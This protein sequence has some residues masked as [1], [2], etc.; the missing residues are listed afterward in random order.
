[1]SYLKRQ[2]GVTLVELVLVLAITA[3]AITTAIAVRSSMRKDISFSTSI[4][5]IKNQIV[6]AKN[7]S[8]QSVKNNSA[9][10]GNTNSYDFG[11]AVEFFPA[12]DPEV[13]AP[14]EADKYM[15]VS[16]LISEQD[17][18]PGEGI[19]QKMAQC[20]QR[21]ELYKDG[22]EYKGTEKRAIIF[23]RKP[24]RLFVTPLNHN[25]T[26]GEVCNTLALGTENTPN[27]GGYDS[28]NDT[29]P[30]ATDLCPYEPGPAPSGCPGGT[31]P[32]VTEACDANGYQCGLY[33]RFYDRLASNV[34]EVSSDSPSLNANLKSSFNGEELGQ[35]YSQASTW[36]PILRYRT[37]NP[38]NQVSAKWTGQIKIPANT[39]RNI[40]LNTDDGSYM[41]INGVV[42]TDN[43]TSMDSQ[44]DRCE[45]FTA[46]N[47]D[48]W[49][50]INIAYPQR[51]TFE[52]TPYISLTYTEGGGPEQFV[53]LNN[54]RS[55]PGQIVWPNTSFIPGL[56]AEYYSSS[57]LSGSPYS[58]WT[59]GTA[60]Y[61]P[62]NFISTGTFTSRAGVYPNW[63]DLEFD[64]SVRWTGQ[65][66]V[67]GTNPLYCVMANKHS[68]LVVKVGG[69]DVINQSNKDNFD[70]TCGTVTA[71]NGWQN[72]SIEYK[73]K[74]SETWEMGIYM[75]NNVNWTAPQF[76]RPMDASSIQITSMLSDNDNSFLTTPPKN[77]CSNLNNTNV[78][79]RSF[80]GL[81][82]SSNYTLDLLYGNYNTASLPIGYSNYKA[83]VKINGQFINGS[84][85]VDF[86]VP[87]YGYPRTKT[88]TNIPVASDGT[89]NLELY[90]LNDS[91]DPVSGRDSN[92]QLIRTDLYRRLDSTGTLIANGTNER[93]LVG[94]ILKKIS[95]TAF[96]Q[97]ATC[98]DAQ[99]ECSIL[100][101]DNYNTD[102]SGSYSFYPDEAEL[103][104]GIEGS[105]EKGTIKIDPQ[106]NSI[107]REIKL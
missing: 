24:E 6:A 17:A 76:R 67:V 63:T 36:L 103:E 23:Q 30:D 81:W 25:T 86:P 95:G 104:F 18:A 26:G 13:P 47:A 39:T 92:F 55:L 51:D 98:G 20:D 2:G 33:G 29:I 85:P 57:D 9:G 5:Q 8:V 107:T 64:G 79:S 53:P 93:G 3:G 49:Y 62:T 12:G 82:P 46:G 58:V 38:A 89:F 61:S 78:I 54:L 101:F 88:F 52:S 74:R 10:S 42:V 40:C 91:F 1:M 21:W 27:Y 96:A 37:K 84:N 94:F 56:K 19:T 100:I 11:R 15:R 4:E 73:H 34:A 70:T 71:P 66:N 90:W 43:Y 68:G 77:D 69:V 7:E 22:A 106:S 31:P 65:V 44:A 97:V 45:S 60:G 99:T 41:T 105:T 28:D 32:P 35:T 14:M 83:C 75:Y 16:T 50:D 80:N 87:V 72:I 59:E 102:S 48:A